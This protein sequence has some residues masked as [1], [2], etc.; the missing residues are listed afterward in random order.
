[1]SEITDAPKPSAFSIFRNR[2]FR[3]LW[4]GDLISQFGSGI[5]SIAASILVY[6]ET[7]S[8]MSVG[9]MLIATALPGFLFGLIAG[10]FVDRLDRKRIMLVCEVLR[11]LIVFM[12]PVMLPY[13]LWWLYILVALSATVTQF[14]KPAHASVLPDVASDEELASANSMMSVSSVGALGLGFA[15]AG[16]IMARYPV[17]WAFYIDA[18][19]F[20]LSGAA[21]ALVRI[22]PLDIKDEDTSIAAVGRNLQTGLRFLSDS[23]I[24]RSTLIITVPMAI[25]FGLHN[26]LLL[27]F[28]PS[29]SSAWAWSTSS[30]R[31]SQP[32]PSP[33]SWESPCPS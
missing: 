32:Y 1:M 14:F 17:E 27:P 12:I 5:T 31:R 10:V 4:T 15:A 16:M 28:A 26:S 9:L 24:L 30:C 20:L 25:L 22:R 11:A 3:W 18:L 29:A 8:A 2:D 23:R 19:T 13:G 21:I 7:G 33:L 6:R